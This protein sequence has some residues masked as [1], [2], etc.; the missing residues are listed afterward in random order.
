MKRKTKIILEVEEKILYKVSRTL[1][2]FCPHCKQFVE[3]QPIEE[4][5]TTLDSTKNEKLL[6]G[7][8]KIKNVSSENY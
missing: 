5:D 3:I 2:V 6:M 1:T 8:A 7:L 4:I